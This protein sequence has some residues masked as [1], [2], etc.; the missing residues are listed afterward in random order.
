[1]SD[2]ATAS[3]SLVLAAGAAAGYAL[4]MLANPVRASLRD[5]LRCVRRYPQ[6]WVLPAA[7]G[8]VSALFQFWLRAFT[9]GSGGLAGWRGWTVPDW[10][11]VFGNAVL[12]A[13]EGTTGIFNV[14]I[15]MFPLSAIGALMFLLNWGGYQAEL[16]R[17]LFRRLGWV[18]G[19]VA[20]AI[21]LVCALAA[22]F[23]PAI[24]L[25]GRERLI[26]ALPGSQPGALTV[27]LPW[28]LAAVDAL[29]FVF[30]CLLGVALQIYLILLAY[31]WI[32]GLGFD[33]AELRHFAVRRFA[34]VLK[35]AG[36]VLGISALGI[37]LPLFLLAADVPIPVG[38]ALGWAQAGRWALCAVLLGGATLQITLVFHN[39]SLRQ[40]WRDHLRLIRAHGAHV[41]WLV[42][43]AGLHFLSLTALHEGLVEAVG[44]PAT[45][46]AAGMS[47]LFP[48]G[49]SLL[50]GWLLASWVCLYRRLSS[51]R[52]EQEE[53]VRF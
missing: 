2:A 33:H 49:W 15:A 24:F 48:L 17:A 42:T 13:F 53:M 21:T 30:D 50:S 41:F 7:F 38:V 37:Q 25:V 16:S 5:G 28:L 18:R 14:G 43:V 29:G 51:G 47:L 11:T 35:W 20:L 26:G 31:A 45:I 34:F 22:F 6:L 10:V 9:L 4:L 32:R 40:A 52:P 8:V 36:A 44:G 39:E 23:K 3:L 27:A 46:L 12:P 1:M 19:L